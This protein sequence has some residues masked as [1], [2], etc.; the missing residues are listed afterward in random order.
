MDSE[1]ADRESADFTD[2]RC[3]RDREPTPITIVQ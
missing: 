2:G 3:L 1:V